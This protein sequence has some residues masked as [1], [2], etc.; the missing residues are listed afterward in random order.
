MTFCRSRAKAAGYVI[1][2]P[3]PL[4]DTM[5]H[6]APT[7]HMSALQRLEPLAGGR[8]IHGERQQADLRIGHQCRPNG[9]CA[10]YS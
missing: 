2:A 1:A 4:A 6:S 5:G 3:A 10:K 9:S 7:D 8:R